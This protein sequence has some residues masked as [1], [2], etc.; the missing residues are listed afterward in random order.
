MS[1]DIRGVRKT[2]HTRSGAQEVLRGVDLTIEKG[3]FVTIIGHSGCGKSTLLNVVGGLETA[4]EG[5]VVLDGYRVEGPGPDRA[6]VFQNYSLL[7]W[8]SVYR[9]VLEAT[10]SARPD[11][12]REDNKA[13]A[14]KYLRS[15]GM[16][17][18]RDKKPNEVSGG[19]RQRTAVAR[20]FAVGPKVLLLDEPFGALDALTRSNLQDQLVDLW[21]NDAD[22]ETVLMV[23]HGIDEAIFLAD[24]IVVMANAPLPSVAA[25]I[26]VPLAR[27]RDKVELAKDPQYLQIRERLVQLLQHDL[28]QQPT[29]KAA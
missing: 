28:V 6:I 5:K 15:T 8:M 12:S 19:M 17:V 1:L 13:V 10:Y 20:A 18:H 7:P 11:R 26:E 2:F 23:T 14:E 16:W 25:V 3:E 27:P 22:T 24:R 21:A 4:D 9:N 29:A